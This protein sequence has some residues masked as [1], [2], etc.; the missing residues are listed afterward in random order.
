M[1]VCEHW[2]ATGW[3]PH[4]EE[5]ISTPGPVKAGSP[6]TPVNHLPLSTPGQPPIQDNIYSIK[7]KMVPTQM[8]FE[9]NWGRGLSHRGLKAV[10]VEWLNKIC[11]NKVSVVNEVASSVGPSGFDES[12]KRRLLQPREEVVEPDVP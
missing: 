1:C 9:T 3:V 2:L 4:K 5:K 6:L 7:W 11:E 10:I 12:S 8:M